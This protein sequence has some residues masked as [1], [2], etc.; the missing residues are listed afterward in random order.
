[1]TAV[2]VRVTPD[3]ELDAYVAI[4]NAVT[5]AE[6]STAQLQRERRVR[7]GRRL[8]LLADGPGGAEGCGYAGPSDSPTRGWVAPRVLPAARRRGIGTELLVR[9]CAHVH[10]LGFP[11]T[12]SRLV[13]G[14]AGSLAFARRFGFEEVNRQV[15]QIREL[16][17]EPDA[18][19]PAGVAFVSI[20]ERP[21][22]LREAYALGSAGWADMATPTPVTT[23]L[24][25]WLRDE[26]TLAGGSFVALA[27]GEIVGYS[28]LCRKPDDETT[29]ED[30]MT[31]VRRDW[32][33]RGLAT[34]LKRAELAWAAR[35]RIRRVETWTQQGNEGV[36]AV[37]ERLGFRYG[38]TEID[39]VRDL[40]LEAIPAGG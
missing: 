27:G 12:G 5:P 28:G 9:L 40:P 13:G 1:M 33:R 3:D 22:L 32:R 21:E 38:L 34:A 17:D 31:V 25:D 37:N 16:G 29:A 8:Y 14:D 10:G 23:S 26:A 20:E 18:V 6:A 30:G 19:P 35:N 39:L 11:R 4:W 36:R 15:E 24:D 2:H 7:D